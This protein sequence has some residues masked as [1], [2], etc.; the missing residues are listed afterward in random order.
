MTPARVRLGFMGAFRP[1]EATA[2]ASAHISGKYRA[3]SILPSNS[4]QKVH[5]N[6]TAKREYE[7]REGSRAAAAES[8]SDAC[9]CGVWVDGVEFGTNPARP[10]SSGSF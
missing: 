6:V 1:L 7:F 3:K 4:Y 2:R 5:L 8:V 9:A 10:G